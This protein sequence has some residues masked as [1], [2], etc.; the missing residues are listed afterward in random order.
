MNVTGRETE[1]MSGGKGKMNKSKSSVSRKQ[2]VTPSNRTTETEVSNSAS[3]SDGE[4]LSISIVIKRVILEQCER[5]FR[6]AGE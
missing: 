3:E 6:A 5:E 1:V 2:D 4:M